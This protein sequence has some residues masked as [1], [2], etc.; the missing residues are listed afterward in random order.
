MHGTSDLQAPNSKPE[1]HERGSGSL[2]SL[3]LGFTG[4]FEFRVWAFGPTCYEST[5]H[6]VAMLLSDL[7]SQAFSGTPQRHNNG[8]GMILC[9]IPL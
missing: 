9:N 7:G 8:V 3:G 1:A 5:S 4:V 6:A 2:G